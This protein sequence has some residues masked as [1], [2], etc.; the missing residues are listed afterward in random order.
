MLLP[1]RSLRFGYPTRAQPRK[2]HATTTVQSSGKQALTPSPV[3]TTSIGSLTGTNV[4][5]RSVRVFV[6]IKVASDIAEELAKL[7]APLEHLPVRLIPPADIHLT[8]VPPWNETDVPGAAAKLC[9]A[10]C[11]L[12]AFTLTFAHLAY[13]PTRRRPRLLWAECVPSR[14]VSETHALLLAAFEQ[15]EERPFRPHVTLAR[16]QGNGRAIA[17]KHPFNQT[18]SLTQR[19]QAVELFKSPAKG[20]KGYEALVSVLLERASA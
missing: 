18:L 13:G 15:A 14:E 9:K 12:Q 16:L 10:A 8:L 19:V 7:V 17:D 1:T 3:Q 6:G 2:P 11:G 5:A 20:E 4:A